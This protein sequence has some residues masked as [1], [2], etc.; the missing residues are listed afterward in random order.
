MRSIEL[1]KQEIVKISS[2]NGCCI[3]VSVP[4]ESLQIA[5]G[6]G[7]KFDADEDAIYVIPSEEED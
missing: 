4:I 1:N 3:Y 7:T 2:P 6:D 5:A